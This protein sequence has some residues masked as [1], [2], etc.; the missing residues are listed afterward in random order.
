MV[1]ADVKKAI[2][3]TVNNLF[4]GGEIESIRVRE[5]RDH[6][7]D[8]ILHIDL[9]VRESGKIL[10]PK[11]T[12]GLTGDLRSSLARIGITSFPVVSFIASGE[13]GKIGREA[14]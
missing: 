5:D 7:D 4:P 14:A 3:S 13:A 10:D 12:V 6:D 11:R 2:T 1:S 8:P 9:I